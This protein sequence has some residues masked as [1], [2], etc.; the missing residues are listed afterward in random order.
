MFGKGE[1]DLFNCSHQITIY[2]AK[3]VSP[4]T[5]HDFGDVDDQGGRE[6]NALPGD[7]HVSVLMAILKDTFLVYSHSSKQMSLPFLF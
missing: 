4:S 7:Y 5:E 3:P 6:L 1:C 2:Y